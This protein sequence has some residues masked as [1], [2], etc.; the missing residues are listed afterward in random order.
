M[1]KEPYNFVTAQKLVADFLSQASTL[2]KEINEDCKL[3][4]KAAQRRDG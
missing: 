4:H 3:F 1:L 2:A